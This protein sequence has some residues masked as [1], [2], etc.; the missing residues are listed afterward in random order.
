MEAVRQ[1]LWLPTKTGGMARY[2]DDTY[3]RG[4]N[5]VT[6]NPWFISTLWLADYFLEKPDKDTGLSDAL[7]LL[8][9]VADH[10]LSSGV[11]PEQLHPHTGEP[12]SVSPLT[13]SHAAFLTTTLRY[14]RLKAGK[15]WAADTG[16]QED[17][18]SKLFIDTCDAIH[19]SCRIK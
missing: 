4:G 5:D 18:I 15:E 12:L 8:N 9:W 11:L 10:A 13:W 2:E 16:T 19:G 17:W 3:Y 1:K 7:E 14:L 6:G